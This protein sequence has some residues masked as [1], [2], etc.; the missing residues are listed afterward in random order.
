[1]NRKHFLLLAVLLLALAACQ[2][3]PTTNTETQP[4]TLTVMTHDS[5][6]VSEDLV[7]AFEAENNASLVFIQ[8][9]DTGSALNRVI[10]TSVGSQT[11]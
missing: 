5:F 6:S 9:G 2:P 1:M 10:L 3:A 4:Q 7:R 8:G 11:P